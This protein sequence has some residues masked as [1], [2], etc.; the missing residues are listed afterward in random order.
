[1]KGISVR[2]TKIQRE[3]LGIR[4]K[5]TSHLKN[6]LL[7]VIHNR[8]YLEPLDGWTISQ[9]SI[10]YGRTNSLKSNK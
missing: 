9:G 5:A 8:V 2:A 3:Q 7:I 6:L 4:V 10:N 1:M